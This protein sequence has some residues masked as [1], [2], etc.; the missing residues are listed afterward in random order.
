MA[1]ENGKGTKLEYEV[2]GLFQK[3]GYLSRRSI[4][5]QYGK[6][7][8]DTTDIDVIGYMFTHP[9]QMHKVICD[10]KNKQKS[11][12]YERIF[13]AKGL[14]EF[15]GA[16]SVYVALPQ[17]SWDTVKFAQK[18]GVRIL[19]FNSSNNQFQQNVSLY[20][21]AD[22]NFFVEYF[23]NINKEIRENK[24]LTYMLKFLRKIYLNED[25]YVNMN[26]L[27]EILLE[28]GKNLKTIH[29]YKQENILS[30]KYLCYES[31][32]MIGLNLL[33]ICSD[34]ICLPIKAREEHIFSRL[35]YGD[36]DPTK[37][38]KL[39]DYAKNAANEIVKENVPKSILPDTNIIN[40]G[41]IMAPTYS[42][43]LIGLVERAIKNPDWYIE[44]P[45]ILDYI[46]F[47]YAIKNKDFS[48][49]EYKKLYNDTHSEEKLKV[50]KN[51]IF[52]V[53]KHCGI[54]LNLIWDK[55]NSLLSNETTNIVSNIQ[56]KDNKGL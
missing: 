14:G 36:M 1:N 49:I 34:T 25:P 28:V 56:D 55:A 40:F 21:I 44:L 45:Q 4:P 6:S 41:E 10:C 26:I 29:K 13:W 48:F 32:V 47:E 37:I 24:R 12:P 31:I 30:L 15:I 38:N 52:F 54:N 8:Q 16:D 39:L 3:Q 51:I 19:L 2:V 35:T 27:L 5:L 33:S 53:N 50:A 9:F 22:E 43:D 18:G 17:A 42:T 20:G 7:N 46:L 11:K 23:E